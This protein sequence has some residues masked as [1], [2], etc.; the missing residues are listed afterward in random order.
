MQDSKAKLRLRDFL[1]RGSGCA[2]RD[3]CCACFLPVN[4]MPVASSHDSHS[5]MGSIYGKTISYAHSLG[6][7][8]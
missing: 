2:L 6:I 5:T 3:L 1:I 4:K 8:N 7:C